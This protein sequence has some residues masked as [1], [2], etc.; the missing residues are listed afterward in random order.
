MQ[1]KHFIVFFVLNLSIPLLWS[2]ENN[3]SFHGI[4]IDLFSR[5][6][7]SNVIVKM[8]N[9][10]EPITT[11]EK[12][13]FTITNLDPGQYTFEFIHLN[14]QPYVLSKY[15]VS[16]SERN[17]KIVE[18]IPAQEEGKVYNIGGIEVTAEPDVFQKN[19]ATTTI[20]NASDI[21]HIQATNLGDVLDLLPGNE[22][23]LQPALT[24]VKRAS[25]RDL[26]RNTLLNSY[27]TSII[28]DGIPVSN[29]ANLQNAYSVANN[30]VAVSAGTGLDLREIPADN[31]ETVEVIRGIAPANYGD[32]L[33]GI[34][35]VRTKIDGKPFHRLKLKN[36]PDTRELNIGGLFSALNGNIG[37]NFNWAHSLK[38]IRKDYD[39]TD[40]V[41]LQLSQKSQFSDNR[42]ML[43]NMFRFSKLFEEIDENPDDPDRVKI[44]NHGYRFVYGLKTRFHLS[45]SFNM[46]QKLYFN[47]RNVD[48]F[49]QKH[50]PAAARVI[51][52]LTETGTD[53]AYLITR[54]YISRYFTRGQELS[55]GLDIDWE[56][57]FFLAKLYHQ[58]SWGLQLRYDDNFGKGTVFDMLEPP[59][60]GDR[61]RQFSDVPGLYNQSLYIN[62]EMNGH[63]WVDFAINAGLRFD[64]YGNTSAGLFEGGNGQFFNPRLNLALYLSK[65]WTM[66]AGYGISTKAPAIYYVFRQPA[67]FDLND[68]SFIEQNGQPLISRNE[69]ISTYKF[70]QENGD[71]NGSKQKKIELSIDRRGDHISFSITGFYSRQSGNPIMNNEPEV[72]YTYFRPNYPDT[73]ETTVQDTL[74]RL[75]SRFEKLGWNRTDGIEFTLLT[76]EIERIHASFMLQA[77]Y[78]HAYFGNSGTQRGRVQNY[79]LPLYR[80]P[81]TWVQKALITL[82]INH[83]S[84]PLGMWL[85]L[86]AQWMPHYRS[87]INSRGQGFAV[88]YHDLL[89][90]QI[91]DIPAAEREDQQYTRFKKPASDLNH[92]LYKRSEKFLLNFRLT[93][94]LFP[95][96]ELSLFVNNLLNDPAYYSPI[97]EPLLKIAANPDLF[98]G[99]E[100]SASL[101]KFPN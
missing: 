93:K 22:I 57:T 100:F 78:H 21:E 8:S 13:E 72:L 65:R 42:I 28:I 5:K 77:S 50:I 45:P 35:E 91:H 82:K 1:K 18:L 97:N 17:V 61:P 75:V 56:K 15:P 36:N 73:L 46:K 12:G 7:V 69:I 87:K 74:I 80:S 23:T 43:E 66:R 58:L 99:I 40:R 85:S 55:A 84:R 19:L 26:R 89:N 92:S 6:P 83:F 37:Y 32:H 52:P 2:A 44:Y 71:L 20:I 68:Y 67:Y 10:E 63:F 88:A 94:S 79:I 48:A 96:A 47:Y 30:S 27:G 60:I 25:F 24:T 95:G 33:E 16:D 70:N 31:I 39:N 14:Y 64:S 62:D 81:T 11:S 54:P 86:L 53:S 3:V 76:P 41:S 49:K 38:D 51:S 9:S 90:D 101:D 29:S 98:W 4:V 59:Q 34:V